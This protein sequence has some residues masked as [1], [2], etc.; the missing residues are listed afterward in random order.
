MTVPAPLLVALVAVVVVAA[1]LVSVRPSRARMALL[2]VSSV[3]AALVVARAG[4]SLL[5]GD[6][7]PAVLVAG[8]A[9]LVG[10]A[11][12]SGVVGSARVPARPVLLMLV[13]AV[14]SVFLSNDI[15]VL[16]LGPVVVLSGAG[17]AS[18]AALLV[19]ANVTGG[20]LPQGS[21]KNLMLLGGST[22]FVEYVGGLV[23]ADGGA[24]GGGGA[25]VRSTRCAVWR[26]A[27]AWGQSFWWGPGV[28]VQDAGGFRA[29]GV[30]G[31]AA[32]G[33]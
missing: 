17:P 9:A 27:R 28:R 21:P 14:L 30:G 13:A 8:Y 12:R 33:G 19:G 4:G 5:P 25:G 2:A 16:L 29:V 26:S 3:S 23:A 32:A 7:A 1:A 6:L 22:S 15:V 31:A 18:L 24:R 10:V 11:V 20:L